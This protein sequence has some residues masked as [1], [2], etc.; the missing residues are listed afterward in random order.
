[1]AALENYFGWIFLQNGIS[2]TEEVPIDPGKVTNLSER[3]TSKPIK[4]R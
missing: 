3:T 2:F 4:D 1:M